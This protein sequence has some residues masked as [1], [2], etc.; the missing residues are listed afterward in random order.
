MCER[1]TVGHNKKSDFWMHQ[2]KAFI[3]D[4]GL[5]PSGAMKNKEIRFLNRN[6][7]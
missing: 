5:A 4:L 2:A 7:L 6:I 1:Q 3:H